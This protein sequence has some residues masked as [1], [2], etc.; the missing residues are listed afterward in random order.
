MALSPP[1]QFHDLR[2]RLEVPVASRAAP[3]GFAAGA[4]PR[5][6]LRL[7]T[8]AADVAEPTAAHGEHGTATQPQ[9]SSS[10]VWFTADYE[11]LHRCAA[12]LEEA[13]RT[14]DS[15]ESARRIQRLVK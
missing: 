10:D 6:V 15:D 12:A 1:Q 3:A 7:R 11:T 2:W 13:L 9:P 5:F 4:P 8:T 14:A